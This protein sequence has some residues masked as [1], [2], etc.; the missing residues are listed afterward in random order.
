MTGSSLVATLVPIVAGARYREAMLLTT[1]LALLLAPV[2]SPV[3]PT[4]TSWFPRN[5]AASPQEGDAPSAAER[6]AAISRGVEYLLQTQEDYVRDR[7]IGRLPDDELATW[8]AKEKERLDG[9]QG[10]DEAAEWPYE[11]VYRDRRQR[12][13][14]PSG[15]RV[16]GTAIVCEALLRAETEGAQRKQIE[17]AVI[18]SLEF[19]VERLENDATMAIGPKEGYDVRGWGHLHALQLMLLLREEDFVAK[20]RGKEVDEAIKD[21]IERLEANTTKQGGWNYAND[22]TVSPFMT[23]STLLVLYDAVKAGFAVEDDV[24]AGALD[25]LQE[26]RTEEVSYEYSGRARRKVQMPGSSARSSVAELALYKAGRSDIDELRRA[27]DGFFVG[28]DDLLV[29]K[30]Q[31]GTHVAPY[32]IAPY[33]FFFGHTF[34]AHAIEELPEKER[35]ARRDE[36]A[37]LLWRTREEDVSWN[38]RIFPRTSSYSTAMAMMAIGAK[39]HGAFAEWDPS[40]KKA[41]KK[42]KR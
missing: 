18:R 38:D 11:G 24:I 13:A 30:S 21:L 16:G 9:L 31:Q 5:A 40:S 29:R 12:G 14:I 2:Q 1:H 32:G 33:Y 28:W 37:E 36:L 41:S 15:Y 34:A 10:G 39:D 6:D 27:V 26:C 7:G 25:A 4:S 8:Q 20:E 3:V 42:R 35:A 23:G 19:I 17:A 22:S